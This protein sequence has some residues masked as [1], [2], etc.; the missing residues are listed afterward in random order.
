M[1]GWCTAVSACLTTACEVTI[2][3]LEHGCCSPKLTCK[4]F[5]TKSA[6][7]TTHLQGLIIRY[8]THAYSTSMAHSVCLQTLSTGSQA[9]TGWS[10][11]YSHVDIQW[12]Q[13]WHSAP[14]A[15]TFERICQPS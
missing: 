2:L 4:Q 8:D 15:F 10:I 11:G 9:H 3:A 5:G 1:R 13:T 14:A 12:Q 7:S 6:C